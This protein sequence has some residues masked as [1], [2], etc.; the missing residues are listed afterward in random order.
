MSL[1]IFFPSS[2][3]TSD[4][5]GGVKKGCVNP[6]CMNNA[7]ERCLVPGGK[8]SERVG[9]LGQTYRKSRIPQSD[10]EEVETQII[11]MVEPGGYSFPPHCLSRRGNHA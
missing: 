11:A 1:C 5:D 9:Q 3:H 4:L 8:G 10:P 7:C 2:F 6:E